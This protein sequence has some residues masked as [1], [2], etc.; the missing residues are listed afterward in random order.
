MEHIKIKAAILDTETTGLKE[1]VPVEVAYIDVSKLFETTYIHRNP[2]SPFDKVFEYRQLFDPQKP[3]EFGAMATHHIT[4]DD[5]A[6]RDPYT[7]F[8]LPDIEYL[9]GHN[10][11]FDWEVIQAC[12]EQPSP[13]RIC[14]LAIARYLYPEIDSHKL[15]AMLY[16]LDMRYALDHARHAHSALDDVWMT[17]HLLKIMLPKTKTTNFEGLYQFSEM[18]RLPKV[19]T[20]GEHEG[21]EIKDIPYSYAQWL[22]TEGNIDPYLKKAIEQVEYTEEQKMPK[23]MSFGKYKGMAIKELP[24]DYKQ[25]L[26]KQNDLDP[27]LRKALHAS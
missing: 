11:D 2:Y 17:Y 14:T 13:K 8:E 26:L 16:A 20:F 15:T 22:L 6:G 10:I 18:A 19:M 3:I 7:A 5:V 23:V 12:G 1:S 9:I 25:W 27:Y 24:Y 21:S 4:N